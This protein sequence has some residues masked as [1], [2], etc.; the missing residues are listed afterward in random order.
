MTVTAGFPDM[1][2]M[3]DRHAQFAVLDERG[4]MKI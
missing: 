4:T 2:A 1:A 3:P